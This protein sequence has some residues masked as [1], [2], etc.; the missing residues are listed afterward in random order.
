MPYKIINALNEITDQNPQLSVHCP[1]TTVHSHLSVHC[2]LTTVHFFVKQLHK[3]LLSFYDKEST[4]L[5][6]ARAAQAPSEVAVEI[7]RTPFLRQSP[8]A[9]IPPQPIS[10]SSDAIR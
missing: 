10:P 2:P 1:L 6:A 7:W 8:A 5:Q 4:Y 9:K 3:I